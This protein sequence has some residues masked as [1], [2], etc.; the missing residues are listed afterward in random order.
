MVLRCSLECQNTP[1][2][3]MLNYSHAM[4]RTEF[5]ELLLTRP[6]ISCLVTKP[7]SSSVSIH[8]AV[9]VPWKT[10]PWAL[11]RVSGPWMGA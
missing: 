7:Q 4:L 8:D 9:R 3:N 2:N 11:S 5:R 1:G 6:P 10:I